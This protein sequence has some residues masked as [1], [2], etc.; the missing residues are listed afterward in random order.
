MPR[1][2][3]LVY[4]VA[5]AVTAVAAVVVTDSTTGFTHAAQQ[6]L[7]GTPASSAAQSGGAAD[8]A[9]VLT[10]DQVPPGV[11]QDAPAGATFTAAD[12][13]RYVFQTA[14]VSRG[15]ERER[16]EYDDREHVRSERLPRRDAREHEADDD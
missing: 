1:P 9:T 4:T 6:T 2:P 13:T 15:R 12:G 3:M 7:T 5:G 8:D 11:P 14:S 16:A 10:T